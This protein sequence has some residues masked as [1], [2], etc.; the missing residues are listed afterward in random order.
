[1]HIESTA[2]A[3]P[4]RASLQPPPRRGLASGSALASGALLAA[5]LSAPAA[6]AQ[7][8]GAPPPAP[9]ANVTSGGG[10]IMFGLEK[11]IAMAVEQSMGN[12]MEG[13]A[14]LALTPVRPASAADS[15]RAA[16]VAA[17][18]RKGIEKYRDVSVAVADGF[19]MFAPGATEQ[20]V[21]HYVHP[22]RTLREQG[23][24]D[25]AEPGTLIYQRNAKGDLD[26]IGAM[27]MAGPRATPDELDARVPLSIA[28]WHRHVNYC[29]PV[30]R[31]RM[32]E[33]RDGKPLFGPVG[34]IATR[35]ACNAEGGRFSAQLLGWMVH[36]NVFAGT[37]PASIWGHGA[38]KH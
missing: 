21:Y 24:F 29:F 15:A 26:L 9:P 23:R 19:E 37:D 20:P 35:E 32:A 7:G 12:Q 2:G 22:I 25:A 8:S 11:Q 27:Y 13:N 17:D 5:L 3:A 1:M 34:T 33:M 31:R 36:A 6:A 18:L 16:R 30:D 10:A 28:R 38:H 4:S 14:H